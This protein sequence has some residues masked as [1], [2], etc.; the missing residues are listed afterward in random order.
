MDIFLAV[1]KERFHSELT[2]LP[3]GWIGN[4]IVYVLRAFSWTKC[5]TWSVEVPLFDRY[6]PLLNNL[7][8]KTVTVIWK[9]TFGIDNL[10]FSH[11]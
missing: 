3:L 10:N 9:S 8:F 7:A 6:R 5:S 2:A 4:N 11:P 1:I